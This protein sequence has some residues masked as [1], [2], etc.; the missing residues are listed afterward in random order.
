LLEEARGCGS[1]WR[2]MVSSLSKELVDR[3][4]C[5]AGTSGM[6]GVSARSR[7][8]GRRNKRIKIN[9]SGREGIKIIHANGIDAKVIVVIIEH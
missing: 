3:T 9:V 7:R 2:W 6:V 5:A 1:G 4:G 8:V